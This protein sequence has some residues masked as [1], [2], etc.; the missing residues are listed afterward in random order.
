MK[1]ILGLILITAVSL[2]VFA[3]GN[4][5]KGSDGK[6]KLVFT[7]WRT[8]DIER[9]DRINEAF[10]EKYPHIEIVFQP[11]KNTEYPA[12]LKQSLAAGVGADIIYLKS[13]DTGYDAYKTGALLDLSDENVPGLDSFSDT[14]KAAWSTPEGVVYGVPSAGVVHGVYYRKSIFEKY[15]IEIPVTWDEFIAACKKIKDGG[16]TVFAQGT[17]DNWMLYEVIFSGLGANFYGGEDSRQKLL[18]RE[19]RM[20]DPKFVKAFEK[21]K[22][23]QEFFPKNYQGLDYSTMQQ[24]FGTGNAAMFI[25]GSWEIG[26]FEDLGGLDDIGYFAPPVEKAGDKLQYCFHVDAGIGVNKDSKHLEE[27]I[28]YLNWL[29]SPEFA[30]LFMDET[31]GFFSY[32]PGMYE[33]KNDLAREMESYVSD[34]VPTVRTLWEKFDAG[35]PS[36]YSL[37]SEGI[38]AMYSDVMT[39]KEVAE[40]IDKGLSWYY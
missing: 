12:Q 6:V 1:R 25:G 38:Q 4:D 28:L 37:I 22:E 30:Q 26:I 33:L 40:S 16:D 32:T 14:A 23:L 21:I 24:M 2:S 9:M 20:T 18:N 11:V 3:N 35:T 31:P 39:P 8:E 36:G 19:I 17:K 15:G 13:Y 10:T 34:S 27:A 5:E 7:S 29:A